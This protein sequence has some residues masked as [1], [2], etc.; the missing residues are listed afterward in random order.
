M[1]KIKYKFNF[2]KAMFQN[3]NKLKVILLF[4]YYLIETF[5]KIHKAKVMLISGNLELEKSLVKQGF[6][7]SKEF[8]QIKSDLIEKVEE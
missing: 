2:F 5:Y 8:I 7:K 4:P 3:K 6:L 1:L